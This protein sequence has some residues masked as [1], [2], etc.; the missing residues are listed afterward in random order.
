MKI[1][2]D[3][4]TNSSS[5]S[6]VC[7][8]CGE[9]ESGYDICSYNCEQGHSFCERCFGK[10]MTDENVFKMAVLFLEEY[11]NENVDEEVIKELENMIL[12]SSFSDFS[13]LSDYLSENDP[14]RYY[15]EFNEEICPVCSFEII[16]DDIKLLYALKKLGISESDLREEI[17]Q[18]FKTESEIRHYCSH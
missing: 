10:I 17:R 11:E 6:F 3:F 13:S 9:G 4:V 18:K 12:E 8:K 16:S 1:R 7:E 15:Y 5:S 2:T 14:D